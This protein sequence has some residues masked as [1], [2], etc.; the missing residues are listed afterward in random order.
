MSYA[1]KEVMLT[2]RENPDGYKDGHIWWQESD[3]SPAYADLNASDF[4]EDLTISQRANVLAPVIS[5]I[6]QRS[7]K[8]KLYRADRSNLREAEEFIFKAAT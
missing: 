2:L 1:K 7:V 6:F 5:A 3:G 8:V 4:T